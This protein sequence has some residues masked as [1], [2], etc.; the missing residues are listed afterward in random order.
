[1]STEVADRPQSRW[2]A[3]W[4]GVLVAGV[5]AV[6]ATFLSEHHG[7]PTMLFALL[8]GMA[9][10]FLSEEGRCVEG[11]Q[12]ASRRLLHVGV[13]LLGLRISSDQIVAFGWEPVLLVIGAVLTTVIGGIALSRMLGR[14]L[15]FGVLTGGA[16][17][18][19]GASA[20]LAIASV[21]S[22]N[23]RTER[24]TIFTVIAV[25]SLGTVA[26]IL[27]PL[28]AEACGLDGDTAGV[29]LGATI[30][31]VAQVIGAG[32]SV[33]EEAGDA[34]VFVKMLR[35]AM[36]APVVMILGAAMS[37]R[38]KGGRAPGVPWFVIAFAVAAWIGNFDWFPA[39]LREVLLTVSR[40]CLV[41][42]IAAIGLKTSIRA[43]AGVGHQAV[44]IV[45][46]ETALLGALV[47]GLLVA[48]GS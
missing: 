44:I 12:F 24:D 16:V 47:L 28:I 35:V 37:S 29:F 1:M 17:A 34:A 19:C 22:R 11:I 9:L 6:A 45:C 32:Y 23:E 33:S 39:A 7:G 43:L 42:A 3:L 21:I 30:H 41:T 2:K 26:M 38:E 14:G 46:A 10:Q 4:P 36:L 48:L 20:A 13:A 40:W 25:T 27:Y 15:R 31:D 5:V 18:I 8:L